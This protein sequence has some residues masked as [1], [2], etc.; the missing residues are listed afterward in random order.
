MAQN[1]K[2][3]RLTIDLSTVV[4]NAAASIKKARSEY[5]SK[6]ELEFQRAIAD[7]MSYD[8]QVKFRQN[9]I[10]ELNASSFASPSMELPLQKSITDT[11]KLAR[12]QKYRDKYEGTIGDIS[13]GIGHNEAQLNFLND[14]LSS[15]TD[16]QL[17]SEIIDNIQTTRKNIET[18]RQTLLNNRV[19]YAT[20]DGTRKVLEDAISTTASA[21]MQANLNGNTDEVETRS[22]QLLALKGQLET[23]KA[24]D[25]IS[26]WRVTSTSRGT[27][28]Q[29]KLDFIN[30]MMQTVDPTV[31]V[32]IGGKSY[33]NAQEFWVEKRTGFLE[34]T[35]QTFGNYF[36][37]LKGKLNDRV[38]SDT[39]KFGAPV[40]D[41]LDFVQ[42]SLNDAAK[43]PGVAN[44]ADRLDPLRA[45]ILIPAV[46][47]VTD[48]MSDDASTNFDY[49]SGQRQIENLGK[50]YG[51]DVTPS[52]TTLS[53]RALN[54]LR[55][56]VNQGQLTEAQALAMNPQVEPVLTKIDP[57]V[58]PKIEPQPKKN[59]NVLKQLP[60][61]ESV[62]PSV[63]Q[64]MRT[65]PNFPVDP[66]QTNKPP[67]TGMNPPKLVEI[68]RTNNETG[69]VETS[70]VYEGDVAHW[71][72]Q[73]WNS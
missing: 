67:L 35:D 53:N 19:T 10:T 52:L 17:R 48:K 29:E 54:D 16:P 26:N 15:T 62:F 40:Q 57:S 73:G 28:P 69:R 9:Q 49:I 56:A 39:L 32:R 70:Q 61:K 36:D 38:K 45:D 18:D 22:A 51:V 58:T 20:Q 25:A 14:S 7:G 59:P 8:D 42:N 55:A 47:A 12:F 27:S 13:A 71:K 68:K 31:P 44:F 65:V 11:K 23:V 5:D 64:P 1:R 33:N 43:K 60:T 30:G 46:K 24:N 41:S 3:T 4:N 50:R 72:T 63:V 37:E 21:K 34:G 6:L 66:N 2:P